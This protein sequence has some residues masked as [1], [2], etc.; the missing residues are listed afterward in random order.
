MVQLQQQ[1]ESE[2]YEPLG[3]LTACLPSLGF[4]GTVIGMGGALLKADRLFDSQER[5]LAIGQ[6]TEQ[7]G[8]AFDTTL[9]SLAC[10]LGVGLAIAWLRRQDSALRQNWFDAIETAQLHSPA[11]GLPDVAA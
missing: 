3:T 9:I 7:L 8:F 11:E 4:I 2:V 1:V 5:A 10:S 6:M